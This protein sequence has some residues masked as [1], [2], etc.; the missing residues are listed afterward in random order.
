M[1]ALTKKISQVP[2]QQSQVP[3][4]INYKQADFL[5][6]K[7]KQLWP[8]STP[9]AHMGQPIS[10]SFIFSSLRMCVQAYSY[11][12]FKPAYYNARVLHLML[13]FS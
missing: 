12:L 4:I 10:L 7:K 5:K 13:H 6:K 1:T 11:L 2:T 9:S 8:H 3:N